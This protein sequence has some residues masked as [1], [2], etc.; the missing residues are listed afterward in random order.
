MV[1]DLYGNVFPNCPVLM[2]PIGSLQKERLSEI[3]KGEKALKMREVIDAFRCGGC[4][5]DC[6][7]ITNIATNKKFL[8]KEYEELKIAFLRGKSIPDVIDFN[9]ENCFLLLNGWYKPEGNSQFRFCWTEPEFSILIPEGTVALE[10]FALLPSKGSNSL[11]S[12]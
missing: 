3:W 9:Q 12:S 8:K 4:W 7:V 10:I 2:K 5:N 1:I 11:N 6:Q